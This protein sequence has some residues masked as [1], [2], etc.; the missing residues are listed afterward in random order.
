MR[1]T[2]KVFLSIAAII[3]GVISLRYFLL[4]TRFDTN[5]LFRQ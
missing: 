5:A 2:L 3:A 4:E 1:E